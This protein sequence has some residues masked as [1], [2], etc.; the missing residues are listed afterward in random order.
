M[1][2]AATRPPGRTLTTAGRAEGLPAP[3]DRAAIS[4]GGLRLSGEN[5]VRGDHACGATPG[6]PESDRQRLYY[7]SSKKSWSQHSPRTLGGVTAAGAAVLAAR[8][9]FA[10]R[11]NGTL[12]A[13]SDISR[14]TTSSRTGFQYAAEARSPAAIQQGT[15]PVRGRGHR[16][17]RPADRRSALKTTGTARP[18]SGAA[19]AV[20]PRRDHVRVHDTSRG[21][22]KSR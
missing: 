11:L 15:S 2:N 6:R 8:T 3:S 9:H 10:A 7:F 19:L 4:D 16:D 17:V 12:R 1:D 22:A 5:G 14:P 21:C 18:S 13:G 20:L